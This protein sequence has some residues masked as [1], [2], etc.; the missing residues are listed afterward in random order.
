M[1]ATRLLCCLRSR[2]KKPSGWWRESNWKIRL[3]SSTILSMVLNV[4]RRI[5][6]KKT[7]SWRANQRKVWIN[8]KCL[9]FPEWD[10]Q[11][12][13]VANHLLRQPTTLNLA[14]WIVVFLSQFSSVECQRRFWATK[15]ATPVVSI[16]STLRVLR[17][18]SSSSQ[19]WMAKQ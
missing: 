3:Q 18:Q 15:A 14:S 1:N 6:S 5:Y 10:R 8:P 16:A 7:R 11:S 4:R 13:T 19:H 9:Q 2:K 17:R 12:D